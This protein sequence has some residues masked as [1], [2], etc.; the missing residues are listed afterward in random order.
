MVP[1]VILLRFLQNDKLW[2]HGLDRDLAGHFFGNFSKGL[3][4]WR[5]RVTHDDGD[6]LVSAFAHFDPYGD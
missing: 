1:E 6:A 3:G 5:F 2:F 4:L